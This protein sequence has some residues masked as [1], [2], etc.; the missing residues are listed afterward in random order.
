M[1]K[2]LFLVVLF[3]SMALILGSAL[4]TFAGRT[5]GVEIDDATITINTAQVDPNNSGSRR[6]CHTNFCE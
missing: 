4:K 3:L 2:A 6:H 5:A 1:K